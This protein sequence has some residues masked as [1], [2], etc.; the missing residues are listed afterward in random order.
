[1]L[2]KIVD[3]LLNEV[4]QAKQRS[5]TRGQHCQ[6]PNVADNAKTLSGSTD[7]SPNP[8]TSALS[9]IPQPPTEIGKIVAR[10]P[11]ETIAR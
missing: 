8:I 5:D 2:S 10:R 7:T 3:W 11:Q 4:G 1:V 6:Y 9:L